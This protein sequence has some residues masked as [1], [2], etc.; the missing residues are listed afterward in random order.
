MYLDMLTLDIRKF[1]KIHEG[2]SRKFFIQNNGN[3]DIKNYG[4][5]ALHILCKL[6]RFRDLGIFAS[7]VS[8][9]RLE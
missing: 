6:R 7:Q 8:D 4:S 2:E 9:S 5:M 3:F 1:R